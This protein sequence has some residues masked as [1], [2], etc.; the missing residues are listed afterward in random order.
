MTQEIWFKNDIEN[1]L[2]GIDLAS[3][4]ISARSTDPE[5][6]HFQDGFRSALAAAAVCFG[7][8]PLQRHRMETDAPNT[9]R[10]L[11]DRM[12]LQAN[13]IQSLEP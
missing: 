13:R 9:P 10:V 11:Q 6:R 5:A 12:L 8:Q 2:M 3:D 4:T 1:V 7:L